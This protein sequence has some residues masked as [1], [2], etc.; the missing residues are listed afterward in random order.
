MAQVRQAGTHLPLG[1]GSS[2][3]QAGSQASQASQ[4]VTSQP[5]AHLPRREGSSLASQASQAGRPVTSPSLEEGGL[6][7]SS[8]SQAGAHLPSAGESSSQAGNNPPQVRQAVKVLGQGGKFPGA[9]LGKGLP[10]RTALLP[11][12]TVLVPRKTI[13]LLTPLPGSPKGLPWKTLT[14]SGS[15]TYPANL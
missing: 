7:A 13:S 14:L 6:V 4:T 9:Q 5:G 3:C 15:L 12:Q 1:E 8:A 2:L 11:R 10:R